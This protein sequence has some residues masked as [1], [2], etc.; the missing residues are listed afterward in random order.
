MIRRPPRSTR[1][2]TLFPYTTLFRSPDAWISFEGGLIEVGHDGEGFAYDN[3]LPRH[4]AYVAPFRLGARPVS[5]G[6]WL[7]FIA[8]GG[9]RTPTPWLSD[10]WAPVQAQGWEAPAY[11]RREGRDWSGCTLGGRRAADARERGGPPRH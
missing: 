9:Y 4:R 6:A 8:D 7:E 5:C 1:T 3:E 2:D 11:W 10:G